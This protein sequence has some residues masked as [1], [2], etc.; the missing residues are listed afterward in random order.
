M[1]KIKS[2]ISDLEKK[3]SELSSRHAQNIKTLQEIEK[4]QRSIL[5][6]HIYISGQIS[7]LNDLLHEE[8]EDKDKVDLEPLS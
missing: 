4:E 2:K 5:S 6:E 1:N 7:G 3:L 8:E